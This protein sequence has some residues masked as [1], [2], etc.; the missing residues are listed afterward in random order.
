MIMLIAKF[1]GALSAYGRPGQIAFAIAVGITLAVIPGGTLLWILILIPMMLI[2]INQAAMLGTMGL[3]RLAAP[4]FDPLT[5]SVGYRI[6]TVPGLQEP[7]GRF[8]SMPTVSWFRLDD[9]FIF[10]SLV[11]G[12]LG[13]PL[14]FAVGILL[15][16]V[17]RRYLA[18]KVKMLFRKIGAK[19]PWLKK[20]GMGIS[21]S[22]KLGVSL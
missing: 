13:W 9:S 22:R 7:M 17:F 5:E 1:I 14:F 4:L 15:V 18:G 11:V 21:A 19:V 3:V 6:L 20:L 16:M 2:R 10:G 12:V 8:L